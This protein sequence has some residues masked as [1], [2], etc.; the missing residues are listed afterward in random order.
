M[1]K[2]KIEVN[3]YEAPGNYQ[4]QPS[5]NCQQQPNQNQNQNPLSGISSNVMLVPLGFLF[6]L[7]FSPVILG[8]TR[9]INYAPPSSP[10][11][12]NNR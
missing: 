7:F 4:Q 12:I 9:Q 1:S 5:N 2:P 10:V 8:G 6:L 3:Y 11:I